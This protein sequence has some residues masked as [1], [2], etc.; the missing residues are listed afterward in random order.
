MHSPVRRV[1]TSITKGEMGGKGREEGGRE[2]EREEVIIC[3]TCKNSLPKHF[4]RRGEGE[5][6]GGD[7]G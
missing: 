6:G 1:P 5:K 3:I 4:K 2:R 7:R